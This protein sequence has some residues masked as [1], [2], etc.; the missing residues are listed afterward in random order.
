MNYNLIILIIAFCLVCIALFIF[1]K[2]KNIKVVKQKEQQEYKQLRQQQEKKLKE[3]K[4][5]INQEQ[6]EYNIVHDTLLIKKNEKSYL[7]KYITNY[8]NELKNINNQIQQTKSNIN[9]QYDI[10][11]KLVEQRLEDFKKVSKQAA[12]HYV[13][14]LE[15]DYKS[16]EAAHAQTIARLQAEY[17]STAAALNQLKETRKAAHE[18][19]LK[20]QE[21]KEN[22]DNYRL[23]IS[24][25]D[26]NDIHSLE[27]IKPSF[28]KPRV[29]SMLIWQY[30]WQPIAKKKFPII[31][32]DKTKIGIYKITNILTN[33][34]YIGQSTDIYTRWCT[35]CKAGLGID[36]PVGNK[37]Y[38]SIKEDGLENFTFE[39]LCEC[40]KQEL[41]EKERYFIEL[42]QADLYGYNSVKG[43]NSK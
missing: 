39:L 27:K 42:Y 43:N 9:K 41:D 7:Q 18:A 25:Q 10:E 15:E 35:H 36:T 6:K 3:L 5:K 29:L 16:A 12:E 17:N 21:V 1:Y 14:V 28:N 24:Y 33:Q 26:L 4:Q 23:T 2:V 40:S 30:Y 13:E 11:S 34:C 19:L 31:L 8:K 37:L 20:E 32:Q 22:K 38:Q